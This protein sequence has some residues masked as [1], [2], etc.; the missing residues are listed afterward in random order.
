[1]YILVCIY[2]YEPAFN[3][4][5]SFREACPKLWFPIEGML[6]IC[7]WLNKTMGSQ[8]PLT[9]GLFWT[10]TST[11]YRIVGTV[12]STVH[13]PS[14]TLRTWKW[15]PTR[16]GRC[17][18]RWILQINREI[19]NERKPQNPRLDLCVYHGFSLV[20]PKSNM[21]L[22]SIRTFWYKGSAENKKQKLV[23]TKNIYL[24][25]SSLKL[26]AWFFRKV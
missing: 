21:I 6:P 5:G 2:I 8:G 11:Q 12:R 26:K 10:A 16:G 1:M 19:E 22:W 18:T 23:R 20:R 25:N 4:K 17:Y 3:R 14:D 24:K 13:V 9:S 15:S 7:P